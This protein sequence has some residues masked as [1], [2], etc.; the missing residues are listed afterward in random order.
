M[1]VRQP[2]IGDIMTSEVIFYDPDYENKLKEF[3]KER[4]I[5]Y[6]P[7]LECDDKCYKL[8][9]DKFKELDINSYQKVSVND[10]IFDDTILEKF[11]KN[12]VLFVFDKNQLVGI[13]HFSDYNRNPVYVFLYQL[14]LDFEKKLRNL[15][16]NSG[17]T[18]EDMIEFF[19]SKK[20]DDKYYADKFKK[21]TERE[22]KKEMKQLKPF[23][24]FYLEDL[25]ALIN[26]HKILKLSG[27][28]RKVRNR[29]MHFVNPVKY[30]N[31]EKATLIYDF[32][33]FEEF[34][35][36]VKIFFNQHKK[37][38]NKLNLERMQI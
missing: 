24:V 13:I 29:I 27:K 1:N 32:K 37:V 23:Q 26:H 15:L 20:N 22:K 12:H 19:N 36:E 7:S 33:S 9:K 8:E 34:F 38:T 28:V 31:Y 17:L 18:N 6:L 25:I 11:R 10:Y 3:C 4:N 5:T 14:I 2:V 21:Y 16:I 30:R 35:K